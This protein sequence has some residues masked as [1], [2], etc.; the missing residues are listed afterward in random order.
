MKGR[1]SI[2]MEMNPN[3]LDAQTIP[4]DCSIRGAAKGNAPPNEL[5]K[6]V[7]PA[8]TLATYLGYDS[9]R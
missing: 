2:A 7:F 8:N 4:R 9:P 6:K 3:V 5:L 1:G